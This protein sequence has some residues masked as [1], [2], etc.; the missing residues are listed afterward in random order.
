MRHKITSSLKST[1]K[2]LLKLYIPTLV[3]LALVLLV[4]R[5]TGKPFQMF[6]RDPAALTG[7]HPLLGFLSNV[8]IL[9]WAT[10]AAVC[11]FTAGLL[12]A[13]KKHREERRFIFSAGFITS[14]LMLDDLFLV[15]EE[16]FPSY[17]GGREGMI[18]GLYIIVVF[19]FM[20]RYKNLILK[21]AS[22]VF[23]LALVFFALSSIIDALPEGLPDWRFI[24]EDGFKLLG[25]VSWLGYF[26]HFCFQI[27]KP[28]VLK[29][30]PR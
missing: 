29:E 7:A 1:Y 15:H 14:V 25:I 23:F 21:D 24:F 5:Y 16:L 26:A 8:G 28:V 9:L 30:T 6:T 19:V 17:L 4:S 18:I 13:G 3:L 12:Y 10:C 2:L 20:A 11:F 22:P 27:I